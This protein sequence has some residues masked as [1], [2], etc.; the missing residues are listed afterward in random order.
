MGKRQDQFFFMGVPE[1]TNKKPTI[2][3]QRTGQ[4]KAVL[5]LE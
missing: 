4:A 3:T 1:L 5:Y 2:Y